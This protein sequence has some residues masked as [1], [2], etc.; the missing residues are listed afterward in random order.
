GLQPIGCA[1]KITTFSETND[2]R[3][4]ITL[5][6]LSRFRVHEELSVQTPYRQ[7]RVDFVVYQAD[8]QPPQGDDDGFDR[9]RLLSALKGYLERRSLDVDWETAKAAPAEALVNSL[10]MALPFDPPEKQALLEAPE[11]NERRE[12]LV[13]L[14]EIDAKAPDEEDA[15]HMVQ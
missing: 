10:A 11:L 14:M 6:G 12:A 13:A 5:T 7:T 8:L 4:L 15:P 9:L 2:G 1:G 3:Y